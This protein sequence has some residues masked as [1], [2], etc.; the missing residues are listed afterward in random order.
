VNPNSPTRGS[1]PRRPARYTEPTRRAAPA[2]PLLAVVIAGVVVVL[3]FAAGI[4]AEQYN[5]GVPAAAT[6]QGTPEGKGGQAGKAAPEPKVAP[7][8]DGPGVGDPVRD[9]KFEFVVS[10]VDC[11]RSRFGIEQL[12]RIADGRFCLVTVSVRNI[13]GDTRYFVGRAQEAI[14]LDGT[15]HVNDEITAVYA[16]RDT[17]TFLEKLDPGEKTTVTLVFDVPKATKLTSLELHDSPLSG[18]VTVSLG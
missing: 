6:S 7:V 13:G 9:G 3:L 15:A 4:A 17:D 18:G 8:D 10:Q 14:D 16:N 1:V 2:K 5:S 12:E 11:S